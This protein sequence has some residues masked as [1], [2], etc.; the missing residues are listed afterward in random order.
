MREPKFKA[1]D[2]VIVVLQG[3]IHSITAG[4]ILFNG[5]GVD[6]VQVQL[7]SDFLKSIEKVEDEA[8]NDGSSE[9][10]L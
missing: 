9:S 3:K 7:R 6:K 4:G 8:T 1:G 2:K 5:P 10:G